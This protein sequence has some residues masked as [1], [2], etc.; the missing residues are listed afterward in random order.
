MSRFTTSD[1][2]SLAYEDDG[3]GAALLCLPGLTRNARDFDDLAAALDGRHRMIRLTPRGR[4]ASDRDPDFRNYNVGVEARDA[5]ELLDHLGLRRAVIVGTSRG[6][7]LAMVLAATA[8]DRL[9]GVLLNDIGPE[10]A[11]EGLATIRTY[12]GVAPR[13]RD[14]AGIAAALRA[15]M[16]PAFAG[17]DAAR[18]DTLARRWFD[19]GPDG[20]PVLNY[21]PHLR[22]AFDAGASD[23][24]GDDAG[25]WP[26]FDAMAG[27][28]LAVVRGAGSDILSSET[29]AAMRARRPDLIVAEVPGRGHVPFLDEPEA[30][31]ALDALIARVDGSAG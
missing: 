2:L 23:A 18:W 31:A 20:A 28:P 16:E 11:P 30:L 13:A 3:D 26:L 10:I 7:L 17:I 25:L 6:G 24:P 14:F 1:G 22:D 12:L 19:E 21:D 8:R 29:L 27:L 5:L 15:R 4:G 9:A